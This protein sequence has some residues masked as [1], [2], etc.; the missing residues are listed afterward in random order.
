MTYEK[1]TSLKGT[2]QD[3]FPGT[4]VGKEP[5]P[6][7]DGTK[8]LVVCHTPIG[9]VKLEML[10]KPRVIGKKTHYTNRFGAATT[11]EYEYDDNEK[12]YTFKAYQMSKVNGEW[13]E[14][15]SDSFSGL[16]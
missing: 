12:S 6:D 5:L 10:I 11:V 3:K 15:K 16:F 2:L 9:Q 13:E 4:Q 7:A 1:W 8:E 14:I